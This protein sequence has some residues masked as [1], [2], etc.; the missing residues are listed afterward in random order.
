MQETKE[1]IIKIIYELLNIHDCLTP[2]LFDNNNLLLPH[3]QEKLSDVCSFIKGI[4]F[5]FFKNINL[6]DIILTGSVCSY[7]WNNKSDIDIFIIVE[8]IAPEYPLLAARIFDNISMFLLKQIWKPFIKG[9]PL[10]VSI[11]P[12]GKYKDFYQNNTNKNK[13]E[14]Y[15]YA[16]YSLLQNKWMY[17]PIKS[18]YPFTKSELYDEY[19]KLGNE[20]KK[21]TDNLEKTPN[22]FLTPESQNKLRAHTSNIKK[23]AF[24]CKEYN[25]LHEYALQYNTYRV[26]KKLK[27]FL[28]YHKYISDSFKNLTGA[29]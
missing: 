20:L 9:H 1:D 16:N 24:L 10:D 18:K 3:I 28:P 27:L 17:E 15:A 4:A 14:S 2:D 13:I 19:I 7:A 6:V 11:I 26:A 5:P 22:G 29:K 23:E 12:V 25:E 8:D 21:Y